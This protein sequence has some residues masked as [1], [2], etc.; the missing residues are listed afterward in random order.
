MEHAI[1]NKSPP[2]TV[3]DYVRIAKA[4]QEKTLSLGTDGI[5]TVKGKNRHIKLRLSI[6]FSRLA[7]L[8]AKGRLAKNN[9]EK[10][11]DLRKTLTDFRSRE[12][13]AQKKAAETLTRLI[14]CNYAITEAGRWQQVTGKM[15]LKE[16]SDAQS[17]SQKNLLE[18]KSSLGKYLIKGEWSSSQNNHVREFLGK[19]KIKP[20]QIRNDA[21]EPFCQLYNKVITGEI[22]RPSPGFS[23]EELIILTIDNFGQILRIAATDRDFTQDLLFLI[24]QNNQSFNALARNIINNDNNPTEATTNFI[25]MTSA[26]ESFSDK[27]FMKL[28]NDKTI[29]HKAVSVASNDDRNFFSGCAIISVVLSNLEGSLSNMIAEIK[30]KLA[31]EQPTTQQSKENLVMDLEQNRGLLQSSLEN[32]EREHCFIVEQEKKFN[33][34]TVN[35]A[36][37]CIIAV[38]NPSARIEDCYPVS[39]DQKECDRLSSYF[40]KHI[41]ELTK[42]MDLL[43][44]SEE[45]FHVEELF[46]SREDFETMEANLLKKL[47]TKL[48]ELKNE[49]SVEDQ[50]QILELENKINTIATQDYFLNLRDLAGSKVTLDKFKRLVLPEGKPLGPLNENHTSVLYYRD[51]DEWRVNICSLLADDALNYFQKQTGEDEDLGALAQLIADN[52]N[53]F[54]QIFITASALSNGIDEFKIFPEGD[55]VTKHKNIVRSRNLLSPNKNQDS[56]E[57]FP[58]DN[59][60]VEDRI[61]VRSRGTLARF[62]SPFLL[63]LHIDRLLAFEAARIHLPLFS[64][65]PHVI[66][67]DSSRFY[68][69]ADKEPELPT[70]KAEIRKD[71]ANTIHKQLTSARLD[72]QSS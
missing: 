29:L 19:I 4:N 45:S 9:K 5:L 15:V 17:K 28:D 43:F 36:H 44:H 61:P 62:A 64:N 18:K 70:D 46:G 72:V 22:N 63:H 55:I 71:I 59:I 66:R 32:L 53:S 54:G 27:Y 33:Q 37:N 42:K 35:H 14:N 7:S 69:E 3:S 25:N 30:Q 13:E 10:T 24:N 34:N 60:T 11:D 49:R 2:L 52:N 38:L 20:D 56:L 48:Q 67:S 39:F 31:N 40:E 26:F 68:L 51:T 6:T 12:R 1:S 23:D 41:E 57:I 21:L 47:S 65:L 16:V 50:A 8:F 58:K